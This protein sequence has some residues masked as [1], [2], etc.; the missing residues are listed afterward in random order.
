MVVLNF[1]AESPCQ[2]SESVER[3]AA[4]GQGIFKP[5]VPVITK[6]PAN[7]VR[8]FPALFCPVFHTSE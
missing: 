7:W 8:I 4:A 5:D 2:F 6:F 3:R 1:D